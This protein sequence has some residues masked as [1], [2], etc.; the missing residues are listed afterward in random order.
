MPAAVRIQPDVAYAMVQLG[1]GTGAIPT[2]LDL[3]EGVAYLDRRLDSARG[4]GGVR[5]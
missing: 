2:A 4:G 3:E 5:A 1:M